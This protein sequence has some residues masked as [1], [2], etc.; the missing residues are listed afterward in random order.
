MTLAKTHLPDMGNLGEILSS[1]KFVGTLLQFN[2]ALLI[3]P[4]SKP[5]IDCCN[6]VQRVLGQ[7]LTGAC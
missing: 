3:A 7:R 4:S 5:L 2:V 6:A 1:S